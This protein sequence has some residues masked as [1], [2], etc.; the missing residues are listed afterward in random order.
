MVQCSEEYGCVCPSLNFG[1]SHEF[2]GTLAGLKADPFFIHLFYYFATHNELLWRGNLREAE[3]MR[4]R[5]FPHT[6]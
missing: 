1:I 2:C 3:L 5:D 4:N 6:C